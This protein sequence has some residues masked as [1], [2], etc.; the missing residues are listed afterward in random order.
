MTQRDLISKIQKLRQIKPRKDWVL[1]TK[2]KIFGNVEGRPQ[3]SIWEVLP[4]IFFQPKLILAE[5][6]TIFVFFGILGSAQKSLPGDPLF[7]IKKVQERTLAVF[8]SQKDLPKNQLE[9]ASRR[10]EEL[11]TIAQSNQVKKLA[12]ALQEYQASIVRAAEGLVRASATT[13][14]SASIKKIAEQA[15]K[16]EEARI[17]LE[18]IYGIA[19][20]EAKEESNPTKVVTEWLIKDLETR[21]LTKE[22]EGIFAEAKEDFSAGNYNSALIKILQLS[23]R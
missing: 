18:K 22:Q 11:A 9:L 15:Q 5:V 4:R 1:L 7:L 6:L 23:D 21:T 19:G 8:V 20:L 12:P 13:T 17:N 3:H 14:D 16:L 2:N 10:L